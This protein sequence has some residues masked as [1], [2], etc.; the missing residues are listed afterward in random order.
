MCHCCIFNDIRLVFTMGGNILFGGSDLNLADIRFISDFMFPQVIEAWIRP[1]KPDVMRCLPVH[2]KVK[3]FTV[4]PAFNHQMRQ[5]QSSSWSTS[6]SSW[7]W[8]TLHETSVVNGSYFTCDLNRNMTWG[9][10]AA[11]LHSTEEE[12]FLFFKQRSPIW[13]NCQCKQIL[14]PFPNTEIHFHTTCWPFRPL[15]LLGCKPPTSYEF[16]TVTAKP[17]ATD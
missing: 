17:E 12:F 4:R 16:F 3:P 5:Q 10:W 6:S 7:P 11:V 14:A 2:V 15:P 8:F 9:S 13:R 1:D